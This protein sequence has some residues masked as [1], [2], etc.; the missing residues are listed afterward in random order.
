MVSGSGSTH[1]FDTHFLRLI[2]ATSPS[3]WV[4]SM[5]ATSLNIF[6]Q[7]VL[8]VPFDASGHKSLFVIIGSNNIR[9]YTRRGFSGSRP[10]ILHLDPND[11][12][13]GKHDH[14][15]VADKLCTWLNRIWRWE[16][17][18]NDYNVMPF[19]KRTMPNVRP[20]GTLGHDSSGCVLCRCLFSHIRCASTLASKSR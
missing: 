19:N 18:E 7:N 4:R 13:R 16:H 6:D 11:A 12:L 17:A 3:Q 15:A 1:A 8:L 14:H 9:D 10:C 20:Y 5:G 2:F